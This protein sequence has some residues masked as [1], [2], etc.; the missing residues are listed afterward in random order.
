MRS[1]NLVLVV[2]TGDWRF[3]FQSALTHTGGRPES[4]GKSGDVGIDAKGQRACSCRRIHYSAVHNRVE[5]SAAFIHGR[6]FIRLLF[7]VRDGL[8]I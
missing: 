7:A 8:Q 5:K 4:K 2:A 1:L 6:Q 3:N